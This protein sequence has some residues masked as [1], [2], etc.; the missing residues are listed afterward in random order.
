MDMLLYDY[1]DDSVALDTWF[2]KAKVQFIWDFLV[3]SILSMH[4]ELATS[5]LTLC[6]H[7]VHAGIGFNPLI[8]NS[9]GC[10]SGWLDSSEYKQQRVLFIRMGEP[11]VACL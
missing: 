1:Y 6:S 8:L 3:F 9:S 2:P 4:C 10:S 11:F 7:P 5:V